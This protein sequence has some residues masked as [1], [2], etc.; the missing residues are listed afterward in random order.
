MSDDS[1]VENNAGQPV[2][3]QIRLKGHLSVHWA[4]WFDGLAI[5]LEENGDSV[6]T[7]PLVDQAALYG[8]LRRVRDL[9]LPLL[10]V[11]QV[12]ANQSGETGGVN[13]QK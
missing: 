11:T 1:S 9:G 4:D 10:S 3:Y 13:E 5:R 12:K 8:L 7:G 2:V 6:L